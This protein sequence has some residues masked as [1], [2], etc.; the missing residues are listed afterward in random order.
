MDTCWACTM[1]QVEQKYILQFSLHVKSQ[2]PGEMVF[3]DMSSMQPPIGVAALPKLH[4][5]ILVDEC[6][7]FKISQF[8][9]RKDQMAEATCKL[10]KAWK[11]K[12]IITKF[13][14]MD[15]AGENRLFKQRAKSKD[16]QLGIQTKGYTTAQCGRSSRLPSRYRDEMNV[17]A[18][19]GLVS[20]N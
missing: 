12:G 6:T 18:I 8:F 13:V 5:R 17:A 1:A 19:T 15:N 20:N 11:D 7:N 14:W 3:L 4:W 2:V 10:L 9:H 16:W